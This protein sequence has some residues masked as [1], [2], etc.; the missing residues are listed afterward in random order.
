MSKGSARTRFSVMVMTMLALP[1]FAAAQHHGG[2]G[3]SA[4]AAAGRSAPG[5]SRAVAPSG[6]VNARPQSGTQS[7]ARVGAPMMRTRNGGRINHRNN[8]NGNFNNGNFASNGTDFQ[9]VPGLGFDYPH[10]AAVSGNRGS[11]NGRFAGGFG[12]G[13]PFGFSGFLLSPSVIGDDIPADSQTADAQSSAP[14]DQEVADDAPPQR[15]PRRS[16]SARHFESDTE[17]APAPPREE[18]Q[19]V[20]VRR[21]GSLVFAVAYAWESGTLRYITPD[22]LRR[23]IGRDALDIDA[24]QQFNEQRGVNFRAPA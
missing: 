21:D 17:S 18:E 24:T 8:N 14:D 16:R 10:L 5:I 9:N 19:Y 13:F 11:H 23:S 15:A 2:A 12:G 1:A 22:G 4:P 6:H 20:F 7:A 3:A